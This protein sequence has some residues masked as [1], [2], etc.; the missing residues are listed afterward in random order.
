MPFFATYGVVS[1]VGGDEF[2]EITESEYTSAISSMT[3]PNTP[4]LPSISGDELTL[5]APY[6][7][8][9]TLAMESAVTLPVI[10]GGARTPVCT[11]LARHPDG[12]WLVGDDGRDSESDPTHDAGVIYYN[13]SWVEQ[14]RYTLADLNIGGDEF[15]VQGV[16]VDNSARSVWVVAKNT[17][18]AGDAGHIIFSMSLDTEMVTASYTI[19]GEANGIAVYPDIGQFI[20]LT[21]L[22]NI[23]RWNL[24]D[25]SLFYGQKSVAYYSNP[26]HIFNLGGG[27]SLL[28]FGD[29]GSDGV[30]VQIDSSG[31]TPIREREFTLTGSDAIEGVVYH[32]GKIYICNDAE[33]HSGDPELNRVLVYDA[34]SL[35]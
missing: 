30:V 22:G 8:E 2:I 27:K 25:G 11:G 15:S 33:F 6:L 34:S 13:D 28:T 10:S 19:D 12:G 1:T 3:D 17:A 35:F 9:F 16:A 18:G 23:S 21:D 29:N 32:N 20:L 14:A 5:V 26:D 7:P 24:S 4:L 31:Q